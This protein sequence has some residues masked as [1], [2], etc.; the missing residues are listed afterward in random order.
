MFDRSPRPGLCPGAPDAAVSVP[1]GT[2]S[3]WTWRPQ[4]SCAGRGRSGRGLLERARASHRAAA[5]RAAGAGSGCACA[6]VRGRGRAGRAA[7]RA[8][9]RR[10]AREQL[11]HPPRR[12]AEAG[13][14]GALRRRA[15][16]NNE[17]FVALAEGRIKE[18]AAALHAKADGDAAARAQAIGALLDPMAATLQRVEG[19]LR[20][21]EKERE[22][23]YAG[24][25]EQVSAMRSSSEQ[26]QG[27][28]KQLVNA[29][30]AP[31]VRG[32]WGE[33]QLERIVQLAGMVEHCDFSTQVTAQGERR[34]RCGPTWS[35]ASPAAS[36]SWS[37]PRCRSPR[38][39]RP[40]RAAT[41]TRTPSGSPRTPASCAQ[42]VDALSRQELLGGVRAVARVR[43]AVRARRPVPGGRAAGRPG[44]AGARLRAQR[45]DRHARPR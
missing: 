28:T 31:Q 3:A 44:A 42:H 34:R 20:T 12:R 19:Q 24:L 39:W 25:R 4:A 27:E 18:A 16:R 6:R 37:T 33:L 15:G 11:L 43:G 36:R 23:A 13:L 45:R 30:R 7:Q 1:D 40:S 8:R 22:S 17:Q 41:R 14:P 5:A 29:L 35:S 10:A 26:L 38:T 9:G 32:R 21:V 2:L